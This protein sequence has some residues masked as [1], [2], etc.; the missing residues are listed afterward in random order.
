MTLNGFE[1]FDRA[2]IQL[3]AG[4]VFSIEPVLKPLMVPLPTRNYAPPQPAYR[5]LAD[6]SSAPPPGEAVPFQPPPPADQ[7]FIPM[8]NRWNYDFEPYHRYAPPAEVPYIKGHFYDP[9]NK[10]KLKGDQPIFGRTFF[11]LTLTSDTFLD[12]RK[13]PTPSGVYTANPQSSNFFGSF[14][15]GALNQ[16][17]SFS[18]DL[19]HGDASFRPID[20]RVRVTADV[21]VNYLAVAEAGVVN[22]NPALGTTRLDSHVGLQEA[23]FEIKLADLSHAFDFVSLRAGIQSFTSDFRGFIFSDQE[24]GLRIFG[25]LDSNRYQYNLAYFAMLNKDT[26]SGLNTLRY[27]NQQVY[28]ANL[29]RQ[30]FFKPGYTIQASFHY[31]KDDPSFAFD[32]DQFLVRPAPVG[33]VLPHS[34]RAYYFGVTGDGHIG[35]FNLTNAFYQ[36]TGHDKMNP[37]AERP[38]DIN[39]Q[40]AA[41]ELSLDRDWIRFRTSVFYASGDRHPFSGSARGFDAIFDNPNFAGGFFSFW[42]REGIRLTGTGVGLVQDDS[43]VP[44]LRS[45]KIEGQANFINPGLGLVNAATDFD[46]TPK[47]KGIVNL[48][49]IRFMD[50]QPM[51]LLLFQ[52]GIHTGV[53]ADSGIG[54][55][56]RPFL[57]DNIA[58]SGVVNAFFPFQGFRDIFGGQTLFSVA[59]NVRFRF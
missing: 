1:A 38:V 40:M 6:A 37:I 7:V 39:A 19:F 13:I 49:F 33:D 25:N 11:N 32:T 35:P 54:V 47:L 2:G 57:S 58:I 8:K 14:G 3:R 53:G 18:A 56:Y 15:Q 45:S 52:S 20:W 9:F 31:D 50:T 24:P 10:S 22:A 27:R 59:A 4:D 21:D 29:Y 23:F 26:N 30:D 42:Q 36:V 51:Q 16:D 41:T 5:M 46:I 34:V 12:G 17:F 43:L 48:N 55:V 28:I 44:S